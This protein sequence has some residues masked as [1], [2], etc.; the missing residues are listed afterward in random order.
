M[1]DA[2]LRQ[3]PLAAAQLSARAISEAGSAGVAL[4]EHSFRTMVTLRGNAADK[5]FVAAVRDRLDIDLPAETM[6]SLTAGTGEARVSVLWMGPDEWLVVAPPER[7]SD[8]PGALA[9]AMDGLHAAV[10]EVG[11]AITVIGLSGPNARDVLAQGCT[12]DLDPRVFP[13]G[14]CVRTLVTKSGAILHRVDRTE[15]NDGSG[16]GDAE[17]EIYVHRSFA[18][19]LWH[20]LEDAGRAY[21]VAILGA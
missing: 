10:V 7:R 19:Y 21:G 12:I 13:S 5:P 2:Y 6:S 1:V 14:M 11:E 3:S 18:G 4:R 9:Q 20:W 8:L 17:Y 15:V 16:T